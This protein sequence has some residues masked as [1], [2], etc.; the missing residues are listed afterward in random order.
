MNDPVALILSNLL[1]IKI[2]SDNLYAEAA[3]S[4]YLTSSLDRGVMPN[5]VYT[6][7]EIKAEYPKIKELK[8]LLDLKEVWSKQD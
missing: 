6:L 2:D 7:K 3:E 5:Y 4:K 8:S 1:F